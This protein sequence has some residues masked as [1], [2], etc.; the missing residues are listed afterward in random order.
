MHVS[1]PNELN[2]QVE[3]CIGLVSEADQLKCNVSSNSHFKCVVSSDKTYPTHLFGN[4]FVSFW[5]HLINRSRRNIQI[6][7][8]ILCA[9]LVIIF[10]I[11]FL[12]LSV[13][14]RPAS[15]CVPFKLQSK[16]QKKNDLTRP[17]RN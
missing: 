6:K 2:S 13:F 14:S 3:N 17:Q 4:L 5:N 12:N 8:T 9:I 7:S 11:I 10:R 15:I 16:I 1:Q